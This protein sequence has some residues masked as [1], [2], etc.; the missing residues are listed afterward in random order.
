[1]TPNDAHDDTHRPQ[2]DLGHLE[3]WQFAG[4]ELIGREVVDTE[5]GIIGT[6]RE[7]F[8]DAD[9]DV[10]EWIDVAVPADDVPGRFT[11]GE[12][13][14]RFVPAVGVELRED[15]R[16]VSRWSIQHVLDSPV[17]AADLAITRDEEDELY[18]HYGLEYPRQWINNGLPGGATM[19]GEASVVSGA[20]PD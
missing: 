6:V 10:L 8:L 2:L 14:G 18:A 15:G 20:E 9:T 1:M 17:R 5:G 12:E 19:V 7:V 11:V 13:S 16:V 4:K 3:K